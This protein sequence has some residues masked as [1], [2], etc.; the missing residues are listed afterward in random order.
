MFAVVPAVEVGLVRSIDIHRRQ[1]HAFSGDRHFFVSWISN[2]HGEER[3]TRVS[4]HEAELLASSFETLA[5]ASSS[6]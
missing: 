4:N 6:G 1:Q 5:I 2:P 3:G